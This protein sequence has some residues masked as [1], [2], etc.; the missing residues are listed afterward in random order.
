M[1]YSIEPRDPIHIKDYGFLS[2]AKNT[3]KKVV[4]VSMAKSFLTTQ[5]KIATYAL[6]TAPKKGNPKNNKINW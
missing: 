5:K 4:A 3:G 2:F 6:K 1:R